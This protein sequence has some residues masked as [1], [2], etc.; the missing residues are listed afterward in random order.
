MRAALAAVA[1][2]AAA[3][4][5]L[6][7]ERAETLCLADARRAAQPLRG[8]VR[9]GVTSGGAAT[10]VELDIGTPD[11]NGRDPAAEFEACVL[12]RS[13]QRPSRPLYDQPGW[14]G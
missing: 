3:C 9:T 5:P 10:R 12:R 7:V 8:E 14:N 2:G 13:G 11:L 6:P 4:A 1:L